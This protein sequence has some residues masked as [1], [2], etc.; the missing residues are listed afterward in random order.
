MSNGRKPATLSPRI[1]VINDAAMSMTAVDVTACRSAAARHAGR[2]TTSATIA[3][4][5]K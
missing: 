4:S 1:G 2:S 3:L 5:P